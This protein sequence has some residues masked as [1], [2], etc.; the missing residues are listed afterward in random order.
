MFWFGAMGGFPFLVIAV[1]A[2][3]KQ[4][5]EPSAARV[6]QTLQAAGALQSSG[7]GGPV[8]QGDGLLDIFAGLNEAEFGMQGLTDDLSDIDG[9][10]LPGAAPKLPQKS[11]R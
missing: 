2:A 6:Q 7:I 8:S 5:Q 9:G 4:M 1:M 10:G 3:R 11:R